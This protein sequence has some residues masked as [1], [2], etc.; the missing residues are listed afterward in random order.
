[1]T[2]TGFPQRRH[3]SRPLSPR[4]A[5]GRSASVPRVG[6]T[7]SVRSP[8]TS[9]SGSPR[10]GMMSARA[11][12]SIDCTAEV[13]GSRDQHMASFPSAPP[14]QAADTSTRPRAAVTAS[15]TSCTSNHAEETRSRAAVTASVTSCS[16]NH[17]EETVP[18]WLGSS[19]RAPSAGNGGTTNNSPQESGRPEEPRLRFR[20]ILPGIASNGQHEENGPQQKSFSSAGGPTAGRAEI[21]QIGFSSVPGSPKVTSS[22]SSLTGL[23]P[24]APIPSYS[25]GSLANA[26]ELPSWSRIAPATFLRRR[27]GSPVCSQ[28]GQEELVLYSD[29]TPSASTKPAGLGAI[30]QEGRTQVLQAWA[31]V[32]TNVTLPQTPPSG[33]QSRPFLELRGQRRRTTTILSD[34]FRGIDQGGS[35]S[36]TGQSRLSLHALSGVPSDSSDMEWST[37]SEAS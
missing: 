33:R 8:P 27:G 16:N 32:D 13:A 30:Q 6:P 10:R 11:A 20:S 25:P 1:M 18:R 34:S 36:D 14:A 37:L 9:R 24:P 31:R 35:P 5:S 12:S 15:V 26:S 28:T 29:A 21:P 19:S 7:P 3:D 4:M 22:S 23:S 2:A 17:V